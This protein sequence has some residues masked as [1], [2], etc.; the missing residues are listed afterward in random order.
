MTPQPTRKT[1]NSLCAMVPGQARAK[2]TLRC[3]ETGRIRPRCPTLRCPTLRCPTLR[4]PTLR[5]PTLRCPTLRC[6]T[7]RCPTLRCPTLRCPTADR[8]EV[9]TEPSRLRGEDQP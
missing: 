7:L 9:V 3:W 1:T 4:C 2:V 6:P 8:S 5:C